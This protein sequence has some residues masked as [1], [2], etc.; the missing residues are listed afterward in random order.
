L[1]DSNYIG[2]FNRNMECIDFLKGSQWCLD[3]MLRGARGLERQVA[4]EPHV[5]GEVE[6]RPCAGTIRVE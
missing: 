5:R 4:P 2:R 1:F 6:F 3:Y